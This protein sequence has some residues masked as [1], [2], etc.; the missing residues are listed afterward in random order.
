MKI[1]EKYVG[2]KFDDFLKEQGIFEEVQE[3]A[4]KKRL[5]IQF[6][7][8]MQKRGMSK[9]ALARRLKTSRM[10]VDR[11]LS[12]DNVTVSLQTLNHAASAMGGRLKLELVEA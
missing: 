9:A 5:V 1:N 2:G 4:A 12:P 3:L 7:K 11:I 8:L 10:Q 6:Q